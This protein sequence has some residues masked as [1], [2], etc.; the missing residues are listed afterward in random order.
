LELEKNEI[1]G[2]WIRKQKSRNQIDQEKARRGRWDREKKLGGGAEKTSGGGAKKK[3]RG[4]EQR[5]DVSGV[6]FLSKYSLPCEVNAKCRM[7]I[8]DSHNLQWP[9]ADANIC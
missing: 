9:R 1:K 8:F 3:V 2:C 6:V 5:K 4:L 7:R